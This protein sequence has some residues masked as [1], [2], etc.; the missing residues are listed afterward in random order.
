MRHSTG[1]LHDGVTLRAS[2][3]STAREAWDSLPPE[4]LEALCRWALKPRR[5]RG[6]RERL[7]VLDRGLVLGTLG[8]DGPDGLSPP[9]W[10]DAFLDPFPWVGH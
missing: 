5:Q 9:R 8:P 7:A 6:R 3:S 10:Y 1:A 2:L 4:S